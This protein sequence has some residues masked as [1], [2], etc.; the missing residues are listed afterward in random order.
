MLGLSGAEPAA[1]PQ[2]VAGATP[3]RSA[4]LATSTALTVTSLHSPALPG[5][6]GL[7]SPTRFAVDAGE[8][9]TVQVAARLVGFFDSS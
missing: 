2:A 8:C 3:L 7:A 1:L 4:S 5:S 9:T 6:M